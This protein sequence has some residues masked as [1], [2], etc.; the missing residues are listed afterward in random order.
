MRAR[1][2]ELHYRS[3]AQRPARFFTIQC[4]RQKY[5]AD[6]DTS[7][8]R[9]PI[10]GRFFHPDLVVLAGRSED[11]S[12][13]GSI[14]RSRRPDAHSFRRNYGPQCKVVRRDLDPHDG[15]RI[16]GRKSD[17]LLSWLSAHSPL[18]AS[19]G[20]ID[21]VARIRR[22]FGPDARTKALQRQRYG[23]PGQGRSYTDL[24]AS[25]VH[26]EGL[27][28]FLQGCRSR[29]PSELWAYTPYWGVVAGQVAAFN[30]R[31]TRS[32]AGADACNCQFARARTGSGL[33]SS[34]MGP[35]I[36]RNLDD[37]GSRFWHHE[38]VSDPAGRRRSAAES[39][40]AI[41]HAPVSRSGTST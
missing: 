8:G 26:T 13:P 33:Q 12:R 32:R 37:V 38:N 7:R 18:G 9:V 16:F 4:P 31:K 24:Y 17:D 2:A 21:E 34:P 28:T 19:Q 14:S 5:P 27:P 36:R 40:A 35:V 1:R 39:T 6:T 41:S 25:V 29:R 3:L 10:R 15:A 11:R 22:W 30:A 20:E 23:Y